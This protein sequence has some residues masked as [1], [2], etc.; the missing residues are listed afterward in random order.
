L[1]GVF[2]FGVSGGLIRWGRMFLE[3]VDA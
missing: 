1:R 2:I 3:P